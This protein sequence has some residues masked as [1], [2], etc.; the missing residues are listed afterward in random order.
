MRLGRRRSKSR[1]GL[2]E[3]LLLR[4]ADSSGA[5]VGGQAKVS[6]PILGYFLS[7]LVGYCLGYRHK[8]KTGAGGLQSSMSISMAVCCL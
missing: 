1:V 3:R 2:V 4:A 6:W 5:G 8:K 7:Y